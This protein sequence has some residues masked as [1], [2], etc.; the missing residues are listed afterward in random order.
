MDIIGRSY[1]LITSG[2]SASGEKKTIGK[3]QLTWNFHVDKFGYTDELETFIA[4]LAV[5]EP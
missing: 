3:K 1:F 4:E 5:R 2:S